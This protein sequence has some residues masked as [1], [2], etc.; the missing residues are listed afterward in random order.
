MIFIKKIL[1]FYKDGQKSPNPLAHSNSL[2]N[3]PTKPTY[4]INRQ[5]SASSI[6]SN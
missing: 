4:L 2:T 1:L 3:Y 5:M 6:R